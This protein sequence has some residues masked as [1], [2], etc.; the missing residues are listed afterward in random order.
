MRRL[1]GRLLLWFVEPA[2]QETSRLYFGAIVAARASSP[3]D[4]T[5]RRDISGEPPK[6]SGRGVP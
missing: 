1:I 5:G 6:P 3:C 4:F 2:R